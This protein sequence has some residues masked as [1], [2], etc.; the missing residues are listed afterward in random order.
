MG[1]TMG[2]SNKIIQRIELN[3]WE[4]IWKKDW[5]FDNIWEQDLQHTYSFILSQFWT[6][7]PR[8]KDQKAL[9]LSKLGFSCS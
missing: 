3:I 2:Q 9:Q 8:M 4:D 1:A 6:E 7:S 5:V